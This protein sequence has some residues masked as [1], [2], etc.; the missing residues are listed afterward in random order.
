M[1][2][3]VNRI[4]ANMIQALGTGQAD[5]PGIQ[6]RFDE[7]QPLMTMIESHASYVQTTLSRLYYP[8]A[9]LNIISPCQY[10]SFARWVMV[11]WPNTPKACRR[12]PPPCSEAAWISYSKPWPERI[13]F[14]FLAPQPVVGIIH[15]C[16][17]RMF[18]G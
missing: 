3:R 18:R 9:R 14:P 13:L 17:I 2:Q 1:F 6:A 8:H 4:M 10:C 12:Y 5:M 11:S 15:F 7:V 16:V